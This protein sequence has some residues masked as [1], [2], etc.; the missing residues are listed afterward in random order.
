MSPESRWLAAITEPP[1]HVGGPLLGGGV[2]ELR[3]TRDLRI[4][5]TLGAPGTSFDRARSLRVDLTAGREDTFELFADPSQ[6][7]ST[8]LS[9]P[10]YADGFAG[11]MLDDYV[12]V[13]SK[14]ERGAWRLFACDDRQQEYLAE[15]RGLP[16]S[17]WVAEPV[18]SRC[19]S[20]AAVLTERAGR[21]TANALLMSPRG[22]AGKEVLGSA[23]CGRI[24]SI[25][26]SE[27]DAVACAA[28]ST[29]T[30]LGWRLRSG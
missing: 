16:S 21:E 22:V 15:L 10:C 6:G 1:R 23:G 12:S 11:W 28:C 7:R 14:H 8:S 29:G 4:V 26:F 27:R 5:R 13:H 25:A 19:G 17:G 20:R 2:L 24:R 30:V 3:D 18:V 9:R